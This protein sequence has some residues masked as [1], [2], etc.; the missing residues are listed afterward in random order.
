M[1]GRTEVEPAPLPP[2][3]R[4]T[5]TVGSSALQSSAR[6]LDATASRGPESLQP[7][8]REA[9][10]AWEDYKLPEV[11]KL[12]TS[13]AGLMSQCRLYVGY[14]DERSNEHPLRDEAGDPAHG[15]TEAFIS[16]C[17]ATLARF[18]DRNGSQRGLLQSFAECW[19]VTGEAYMA[20]WPI[21]EDGHP[22]EV[23]AD[24]RPED[25]QRP[26]VD[27]R[28]EVL[29]RAAIG[30]ADGRWVVSLE[31]GKQMRLPRTAVCYR[32]WISHPRFPDLSRSWVQ[33]V[34]EPAMDLRVFTRAQRAAGRSSTI[35]DLLLVPSEA[36]PRVMPNMPPPMPGAP[37][38]VGD[39]KMP[40]GNP[41]GAAS[42]FATFIERIIA[43]AVIEVQ[44]DAL[45]KRGGR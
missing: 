12:V 9:E 11:A 6:R 45:D 4:R 35:A 8:T 20:G 24:G 30:K 25:A 32:M 29:S 16:D 31:P 40:G 1:A 2:A 44:R 3:P 19:Q 26:A 38:P 10:Q 41:M 13:S 21:A 36:S 27:E 43:D 5:M 33:A 14:V 37:K 18:T 28:W 42:A 34:S 15:F 7:E 17:E 23:S 22:T 39:V